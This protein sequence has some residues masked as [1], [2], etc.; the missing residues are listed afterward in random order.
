MKP[1]EDLYFL[2][3][4][5]TSH[6]E[7]WLIDFN[8]QRIGTI[9]LHF[10]KCIIGDVILHK[11][12]N[13]KD[14]GYILDSLDDW[15]VSTI[16]KRED[17]IFSV[18]QAEEIDTYSDTVDHDEY[19]PTRKELKEHGALINKFIGKY[20]D[21]R[22]QLNEH[23][24]KDYFSKLGF[25]AEKANQTFDSQKVDVIAEN[26]TFL[27]YCQ[28]K[29][30]KIDNRKLF[31]ICESISNINEDIPK[32]KIVA[33]VA[34]SFPLNIEI[35]KEDLQAKFNV[36]IWTIMKNQILN[37]LPEYRGTLQ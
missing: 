14:L 18:Y 32:R 12:I 34:N 19:F 7:V 9:H 5:R 24:V 15:I 29:M 6:S 30:G 23:V 25:K 13:K 26:E 22:G 17:F 11:K 31:E 10:T 20:Q 2:R 27:V 36:S 16:E 37:E 33:L 21:A 4:F 28:I 35:L 3:T 1:K 8:A